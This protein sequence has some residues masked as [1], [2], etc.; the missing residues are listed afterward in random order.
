MQNDFIKLYQDR[1]HLFVE[2]MMAKYFASLVS[3]VDK[4][5]GKTDGAPSFTSIEIKNMQKYETSWKESIRTVHDFIHQEFKY[6]CVDVF[7]YVAFKS[8]SHRSLPMS[9]PPITLDLC[10]SFKEYDFRG[11]LMH[12][13][14][15]RRTW[16]L[17]RRLVVNYRSIVRNMIGVFVLIHLN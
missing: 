14:R 4:Y 3:V 15:M 10:S 9:F 5:S 8:P 1:L 2:E 7:R 11:Q 12:R 17:Y 6:K 13:H 16:F